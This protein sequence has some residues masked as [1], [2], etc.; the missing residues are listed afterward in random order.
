MNET[1]VIAIIASA[2]ALLGSAVAQ[3]GT[4]MQHWLSTRHER[5]VLLRSKYEE[6]AMLAGSLQV[7]LWKAAD[8]SKVELQLAAQQELLQSAIHLHTLALVYFS[9]L[10]PV[11]DEL[12]F[13]AVA[14]SQA[15]SE[16]KDAEALAA[17]EVFVGIRQRV[18]DEIRKHAWRY[19]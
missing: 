4:V 19:T 15:I 7:K 10:L 12:R 6:M 17:A 13:A 2:S 16:Q 5:R 11:I 3:I 1:L 18:I 9:E 14:W 8:R